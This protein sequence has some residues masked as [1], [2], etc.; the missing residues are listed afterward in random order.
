M[1]VASCSKWKKNMI[2]GDAKGMRSYA[3]QQP[4]FVT[5][6]SSTNHC[7]EQPNFCD[8]P[9]LNLRMT[10]SSRKENTNHIISLFHTSQLFNTNAKFLIS[11]H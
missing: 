7:I 4:L 11:P 10:N 6:T 2:K 1:K 3:P 9:H 5:T 8:I